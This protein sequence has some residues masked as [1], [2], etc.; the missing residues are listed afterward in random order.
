M[1][2][3]QIFKERNP[4]YEFLISRMRCAF[5]VKEVKFEDINSMNLRKF[6]IYM[7]GEV[8]NNSFRTYA[9]V[10][11]A[12]I[13]SMY[14][15]GLIDNIGCLSELKVKSTPSENVICTEE[16][17][18]RMDAY[19]DQLIKQP[20]H[21]VE[22]DCL[23]L[24][25]IENVTGARTSDCINLSTKNIR[26]GKLTYISQKTKQKSVMPVHTKLLKYLKYKPSKDYGRASKA[27]II[28]EVAKKCGINQKVKIF[29]RGKWRNWPKYKYLSTHSGRRD[30]ASHLALH[31][32][33]L[34][35]ICQFMNHKGN[36]NQTIRY[37]I[38]DL[39]HVSEE[40]LSFFNK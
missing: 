39:N 27:R 20:G 21:K 40:S 10:I 19:F 36:I 38:P 17:I 31:G 2:F 3:E 29:Y 33:P 14:N 30:F 7:D 1:S 13:K 25:L 37:I 9:A 16:E 32:A 35:E 18:A 5:D 4:Q 28:K 6:R 23:C 11:K 34:S 22:K 12:T 24:F 26:D 15:D 8:S